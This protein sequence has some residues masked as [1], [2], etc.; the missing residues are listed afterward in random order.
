MGYV[1][2]T[3]YLAL[4]ADNMTQTDFDRIEYDAETW[5][6]MWVT[7]LD[8]V[9]KLRVAFPTDEHDAEAVKRAVIALV[10]ALRDIE[11]YQNVAV[12]A[13]GGIVAS[14]SSGTES[15]S[16]QRGNSALAKAVENDAEK[17][18][19]L[20][21]IVRR[22][23]SGKHDANGINLLYGGVYPVPLHNETNNGV[24]TNVS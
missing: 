20:Y 21:N 1:S 10:K 2:Y 9:N 6:D 8:G 4:Y 15:I 17:A 3:D 5:L 14:V 13:N 18:S 23:L 11:N 24:I 16:Y 7:T 22:Y 19:Y 12:Q